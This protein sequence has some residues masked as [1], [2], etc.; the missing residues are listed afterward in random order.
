MD[1]ILYVAHNGGVGRALPVDF[2]PWQTVYGVFR[3][4]E[5]GMTGRLH[6]ALRDKL[7]AARP[8][9]TADSGGGGLPVGQGCPDGRVRLPRLWQGEE[10]QWP[11]AISDRRHLGLLLTVL[12]VP[13]S[14]QDRGGARQLLVDHYFAH[15]RCRFLFADGGFA[16]SS[17]GPPAS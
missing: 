11:Q 9:P 6:D 4:E 7:R 15:R 8:G 2:P 14:A 17:S 10:R 12:V 13:A 16:G 3:W 5:E 1:A